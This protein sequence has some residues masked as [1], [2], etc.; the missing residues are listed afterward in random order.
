LPPKQKQN[1][2]EL[3]GFKYGPVPQAPI[4][5]VSPEGKIKAKQSRERNEFYLLYFYTGVDLLDRLLS[6]D[7]RLRPTAE[8]ALGKLS[9]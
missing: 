6:F 5:S 4:S 1:F 3:F 8:Q 9:Y 2:N 7:P